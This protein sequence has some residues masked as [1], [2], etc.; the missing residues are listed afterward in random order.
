MS[1]TSTEP[2][3]VDPRAAM[4]GLADALGAASSA[5]WW[6][7]SDG[8]LLRDLAEMERLRRVFEAT[9]L[10]LLAEADSRGVAVQAGAKTTAAWLVARTGVA[11]SDPKRSVKLAADLARQGSSTRAALLAG[12]LSLDHVRVVAATITTLH[13]TLQERGLSCGTDVLDPAEATMLELASSLD[14]A[15]LATAGAVLVETLAP[16]PDP[17]GDALSDEVRRVLSVTRYPDGG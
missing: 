15:Q 1:T 13:V 12:D 8:D 10:S 17:D 4:A 2:A 7:R 11:R 5:S 9:R 3:A 16:S 14:P 6:S